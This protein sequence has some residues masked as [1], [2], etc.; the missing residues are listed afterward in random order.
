M[1]RSCRGSFD[2]RRLLRH[3][4]A[5]VDRSRLEST[6][7]ETFKTGKTL[8][9]KPCFAAFIKPLDLKP[10]P[11]DALHVVDEVAVSVLP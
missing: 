4:S 3:P 8:Q 6:E 9:E 11:L 5:A 1:A 2:I 10:R 7:V